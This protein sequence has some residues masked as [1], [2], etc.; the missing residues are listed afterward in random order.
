MAFMLESNSDSTFCEAT[1]RKT[2]RARS[3]GARAGCF[4]DPASA[5]FGSLRLVVK[6]TFLD[7][8]IDGSEAEETRCMFGL[9]K[10]VQDWDTASI[11]TSAS[12]RACAE[13]SLSDAAL[14]D[15][16]PSSDTASEGDADVLDLAS[17]G[18][19]HGDVPTQPEQVD[20][21]A[22]LWQ[23][24]CW[25]PCNYDAQWYQACYGQAYCPSPWWPCDW[26]YGYGEYP[27]DFTTGAG[28]ES[29][30]CTWS[31]GKELPASDWSNSHATSSTNSL[32]FKYDPE[33]WSKS[34]AP[35]RWA[36]MEDDDVE[37]SKPV[38]DSA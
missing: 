23:G 9:P 28:V 29:S 5:A 37:E 25:A 8:E 2:R 14:S 6:H 27:A 26:Q 22:S 36:D 12:W 1:P 34:S 10:G 24:A 17:D 18:D 15:G 33:F 3:L 4:S 31:G 13:H 38:I 16:Q 32:R 19:I 30:D 7:F 35:G 20:C 21:S 11:S